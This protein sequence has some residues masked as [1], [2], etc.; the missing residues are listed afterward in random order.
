MVQYP[1]APIGPIGPYR[2][3]LDLPI[4]TPIMIN[5]F[6]VPSAPGHADRSAPPS[7]SGPVRFTPEQVIHFFDRRRNFDRFF[8]SSLRPSVNTPSLDPSSDPRTEPLA[9][10]KW[11][12]PG[13][14]GAA[15]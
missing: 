15:R 9:D 3:T 4:P 10:T 14:H 6:A 13:G 1:P 11:R 12:D 2:T 5:P 8:L 7:L